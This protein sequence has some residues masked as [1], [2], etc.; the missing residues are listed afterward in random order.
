MPTLG[1]FL[2]DFD[3]SA[4]SDM[5]KKLENEQLQELA[6]QRDAMKEVKTVEAR[7]SQTSS[8]SG[9]KRKIESSRQSKTTVGGYAEGESSKFMLPK[10]PKRQTRFPG[11]QNKPPGILWVGVFEDGALL[12]KI[13]AG[14]QKFNSTVLLQFGP[15]G[16]C[17]EFQHNCVVYYNMLIGKDV[18][19]RYDTPAEGSINFGAATV[20]LREFAQLC[21]SGHSWTFIYDQC[22]RSDEP[23]QFMLYPK[24][25]HDPN[26]PQQVCMKLPAKDIENQSF[27]PDIAYQYEVRL[28]PGRFLKNAASLT[29]Q[30]STIK[31]M[32][33]GTHFEMASVADN[34]M[35][36]LSMHIE[37]VKQDMVKKA[38]VGKSIGSGNDKVGDVV[39]QP[40]SVELSS[41]QCTIER[42]PDASAV[43]TMAMLRNYRLSSVYL[44]SIATFGNFP[45][46]KQC[47]LRMGVDVQE[48]SDETQRNAGQ[49]ACSTLPLY[50]SYEM[51]TKSTS[52]K[53]NKFSIEIWLATKIDNDIIM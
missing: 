22:G 51:H 39:K 1:D 52:A 4:E 38:Q 9:K 28:N 46:C 18:W 12:G 35:H 3:V 30:A 17:I 45:F 48:S 42:F 13:L 36:I 27:K 29:R 41:N 15:K 47:V 10:I 20:D 21:E 32:L 2:A 44:H 14:F 6:Q 19:A 8:S 33:S 49:A 26:A 23:L 53:S 24:N 16:L 25:P 43:V 31:L 34:D 7:E 11:G 37:R 5:R 50:V 40:T